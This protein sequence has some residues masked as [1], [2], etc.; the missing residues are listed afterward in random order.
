M[1]YGDP[2]QGSCLQGFDFLG[3][4]QIKTPFAKAMPDEFKNIRDPVLAYR[5]YYKT[6]IF[7]TWKTEVPSWYYE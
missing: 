1:G 5:E 3:L 7:A 6:K 4:H 2:L